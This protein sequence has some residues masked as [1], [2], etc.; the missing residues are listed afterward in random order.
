L[1]ISVIDQEGCKRQVRLE[2][3]GETVRVESDKIAANLARK[4]NI[5][6]FR[7]GH[8]P[9]S[10]VKTRFRKEVR[11]EAVQKLLPQ[12]LTEAI[13]EKDLKVVGEPALDELKFNDDESIAA[14]FTVEVSPDFDL[15]PYAS[16][17]LTKRLWNVSD[18]AV[19]ESIQSLRERHAELVPVEDRP[20]QTGDLITANMTGR[21]VGKGS[22][23]AGEA[24][25][26]GSE[27]G[28]PGTGRA[29]G[30]EARGETI[31][32]KEVEIELGAK[33]VFPEF[34]EAIVGA[35]PGD[36]KTMS[37]QYPDDY[38]NEKIAGHKVEWT[39]EVT[40]IRLK[41]LPELDDEF[42]GTL[43][44]EFASVREMRDSIR[45]N[46]EHEAAERT[47]ADLR[48]EAMKV[49]ADRN[50]FE[51]PQSVVNKLVDSRM[52]S[53]ARSMYGRGRRI[54]DLGIDP[55]QLR[56]IERARATDDVRGMYIL[57]RIAE[58]QD[59]EATDDDVAEEIERLATASGKTVE[60]IKARLTKD[61]ALDSI[62]E[63]IENRKA[64][65]FVIASAEIRTVDGATEEAEHG[66]TG[67]GV[68]EGVQAE[69]GAALPE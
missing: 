40:A 53:F 15:A 19:A 49:L 61:E 36:V 66:Q 5:P 54:E 42:A 65:D 52:A 39:A 51:V 30:G 35:R 62:K 22:E 56:E 47:D 45:D 21:I 31:E 11:D 2:I 8:V 60:V 17:P 1:N 44:G 10:V 14:S 7:P 46:M 9:K 64:L 24:G 48:T 3:P 13:Q 43:E 37:V 32:T 20:A 55:M 58:V 26:E 68:D 63:Q 59:I 50:R 18:E 12:A 16:L 69:G 33:G 41:E 23:P 38:Q 27:P 6:G 34:N 57:Q 4:I 29:A 25:S 28:E 67:D